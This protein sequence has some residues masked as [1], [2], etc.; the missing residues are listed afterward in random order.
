M[1]GIGPREDG[2]VI[3]HLPLAGT[4][5]LPKYRPGNHRREFRS[6]IPCYRPKHDDLHPLAAIELPPYRADDL[7]DVPTAG[8][9]MARPEGDHAAILRAGRW[10]EAVQGYLAAISYADAMVGRL[11]DA[12]DRSAYR[13][14][15]IIVLWGDHGW[16]PGEQRHWRKFAPWEEA[17]RAPP[18]WVVPGSPGRARSASAPWTSWA[19]IP[20]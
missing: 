15:T 16:H 7:E 17:T 9:R 18:L 14:D 3:E 11:I 4:S 13:D 10:K 12:L 1:L 2:D 19:S 5:I 8:V 20:R 6:R